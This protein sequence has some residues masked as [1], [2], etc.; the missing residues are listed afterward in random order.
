MAKSSKPDTL[1]E[2]ISTLRGHLLDTYRQRSNIDM[3]YVEAM[4]QAAYEYI[5]RPQPNHF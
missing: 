5:I 4:Q 2:L 1:K 3:V